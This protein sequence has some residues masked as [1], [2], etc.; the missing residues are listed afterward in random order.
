MMKTENK[1]KKERKKQRRRSF[2]KSHYNVQLFPAFWQR[3]SRS[4]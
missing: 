3:L 4:R 2:I 1:K